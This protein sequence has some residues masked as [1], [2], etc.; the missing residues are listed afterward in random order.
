MFPEDFMFQLIQ[1]EFDN[2][3]F[4]IGRSSWGGLRKL[5]RAF[6]GRL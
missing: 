1:E 6:A 2:L 5:P 4:Q 3:I